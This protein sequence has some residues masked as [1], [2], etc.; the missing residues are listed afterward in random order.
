MESDIYPMIHIITAILNIIGL[1]DSLYLTTIISSVFYV[2]YILSLYALGRA[3]MKSEKGGALLSIFGSPFL[4]SFGHFAFYPFLFSLFL[5]PLVLYCIRGANS[6]DMKNRYYLC[7]VPLIIFIIFC[8]P[9]TTII[10]SITLIILYIHSRVILKHD[11]TRGL[12]IMTP[13]SIVGI[14]FL[15]WYMSF[16][17]VK[18]MA[19]RSL[20]SIMGIVDADT[21]LD[22]N[23]D[24]VQQSGASLLSII[25]MYIKV[26]GSITI[27]F[28]VGAVIS[29]IFIWR[30]FAKR[31]LA[32][33]M[34][35]GLL[36]F[37]SVTYG[38]ALITGYF[39]IFEPIRAASFAIVMATIV[40][41]AGTYHLIKEARTKWKG[42]IISLIMTG[43][44]CSVSFLTLFGLYYSPWTSSIGAH[45][46]EM[47]N[48][49]TNWFLDHSDESIPLYSNIGPLNKYVRYY[50]ELNQIEIGQPTIIM[51]EIPSHFGYYDNNHF[52]HTLN[53][54]ETIF[55][56]MVTNEMM[57]QSGFVG[58]DETKDLRKYFLQEDFY[59]L[60]LDPTVNKIYINGEKE[61]WIVDR[62]N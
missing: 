61:F 33:E 47:D 34:V 15:F 9:M 20:L 26:Y 13:L 8:H 25:E 11:P 50:N 55:S 45:V 35:Y 46:T 14:A 31:E 4:F 43:I 12:N 56:Y 40:C 10:L 54:T 28:V 36:F 27:Y 39:I 23:V 17:S 49:G 51:G 5:L 52:S 42:V 57:R 30:F 6:I 3:M 16:A 1:S 62:P 58:L 60:E 21:I 18:D 24:L 32:S 19:K 22:H 48:S 7:L 29:F 53:N 37:T 59:S 41:G 38:L 44:V 2:V